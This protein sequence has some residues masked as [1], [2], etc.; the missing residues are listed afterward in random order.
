MFGQGLRSYFD[1]GVPVQDKKVL[2]QRRLEPTW[3]LD[4]QCRNAAKGAYRVFDPK[5]A[6]WKEQWD[7][8][9]EPTARLASMEKAKQ[10]P[11]R[12]VRIP[13]ADMIQRRRREQIWDKQHALL[14]SRQNPALVAD[15]RDYFDRPRDEDGGSCLRPDWRLERE[16]QPPLA[17]RT[18]SDPSLRESLLTASLGGQLGRSGWPA[19][20][21]SGIADR[22]DWVS[23]FST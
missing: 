10:A 8:V 16:S 22:P 3:S 19:P 4:Q 21:E 14:F 18:A 6:S 12:H 13:E 17:R 1:R 7:W 23:N 9:L 11:C 20:A 2:P 5:T 15:Q